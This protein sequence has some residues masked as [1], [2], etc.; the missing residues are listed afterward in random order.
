MS[1]RRGVTLLELIIAV[2]LLS[3]ITATTTS[4]FLSIKSLRKNFL[5]RD[6]NFVQAN[7]AVAT[8]FERTLRA[9]STGAGTAFDVQDSGRRVVT[10]RVLETGG[11]VVETIR[12][13]P[14]TSE[15]KYKEDSS[16]TKPEKVILKGVQSLFFSN[17]FRGRLALE[18]A[19]KDGQNIR[20][21][22]Q[23]RNQRT[24]A[25]IIN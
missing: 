22:V 16:P 4:S 2:I 25:A 19:L 3:V 10:R 5:N 15:V 17:D 13:D 8:V 7:L 14:A 9:G 1:S 21:S 24:P 20:T 11:L 12:F 18:L 23:P 6:E